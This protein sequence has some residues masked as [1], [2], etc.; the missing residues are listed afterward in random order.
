MVSLFACSCVLG[1]YFVL[2]VLAW[3]CFVMGCLLCGFL[4]CCPF[5]LF[6]YC[7]CSRIY[8]V[9]F[10]SPHIGGIVGGSLRCFVSYHCTHSSWYGMGS[11]KP[12]CRASCATCG[13]SRGG[14][15]CFLNFLELNFLFN[16]SGFVGCAY[17]SFWGFGFAHRRFLIGL[18]CCCWFD[19]LVW[20]ICCLFCVLGWHYFY[21]CF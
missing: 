5:W 16:L 10:S 7:C 17:R 9:I 19:W 2:H 18:V 20:L 12:L 14:F 3:L 8:F 1:F 15:R 4:N 11:R 6:F 21:Y 13:G